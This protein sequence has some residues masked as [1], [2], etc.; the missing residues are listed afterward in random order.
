MRA[1]SAAFLL[2]LAA[3]KPPA[4]PAF[5]RPPSP[6]IAVAAVV[7][8]AAVALEEIG[9][10]VPRERVV[11]R[12][13]V[14]GRLDLVHVADGADV[15]VGARLFSIDARPFQAELAAVEARA[16]QN[17]AALA[18]ATAELKRADTLLEKKALSGQEHDAAKSAVDVATARLAADAAAVDA[19]KL[20]VEWCEL[21]SPI[22]GRAGR[23]LVDAG[24]L[25]KENET[26][27][28][29]IQSLDP[30]HAEFAVSELRLGE[31]LKA[32]AAG[33][34][35]AEV[36]LPDD[37]APPLSA[38]VSFVDNAVQAGNGT[39]L[40]RATLA[41][42]DRRFWPGR[43]VRIRLPLTTLPGAV[44]VPA[45]APQ[46]AVAGPF[47]YV[48]KDD[49]TAELRQV[50]LGPRVGEQVVVESGLKAGE[51][52]VIQGQ[53]GV[54]PGGKVRAEAPKP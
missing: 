12:P 11:L 17:R 46:T 2:V 5:E 6:V 23:R 42:A 53:L 47:V 10:C 35:K 3:C 29:V 15:A 27:L 43:F 26:E 51:R 21:R 22:A 50:R 34:L 36:T 1:T 31:V 45:G 18:L 37:P 16:A 54:M 52:V 13:R 4:P 32:Q 33:T 40:L 9:R 20:R 14:S 28:L 39:L 44:L 49:G 38:P 19:A 8:E 30:L 48:V 25:V 41:N 7:G 24:N